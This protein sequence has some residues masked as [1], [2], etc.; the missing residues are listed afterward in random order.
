MKILQIPKNPM[1]AWTTPA[2]ISA[3]CSDLI[4]YTNLCG[5]VTLD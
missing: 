1:M 3:P 5:C 2:M 4:V